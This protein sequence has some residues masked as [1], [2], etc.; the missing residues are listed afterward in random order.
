M[1]TLPPPL[2]WRGDG[3]GRPRL[4]LGE[5]IAPGAAILVAAF[6]CRYRRKVL[7]GIF[8]LSSYS[9]ALAL[10][11]GL[12][13]PRLTTRK[14]G[15]QDR[16]PRPCCDAGFACPCPW[17]LADREDRRVLVANSPFKFAPQQVRHPLNPKE[18]RSR[19]CDREPQH[20]PPFIPTQGE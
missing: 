3:A 19:I 16:L 5:P 12:F 17:S 13:F 20:Q 18:E 10:G 15:Q 7:T 8:A 2:S 9:L 14:T 11:F 4:P 6:F 1:S